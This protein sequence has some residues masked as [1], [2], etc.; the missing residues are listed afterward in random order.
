MYGMQ[1]EYHLPMWLSK[2]TTFCKTISKFSEYWGYL[3]L[4]SAESPFPLWFLMVQSSLDMVFISTGWEAALHLKEDFSF[5]TLHVI[6]P[7]LTICTQFAFCSKNRGICHFPPDLL[8]V[9]GHDCVGCMPFSHV[10]CW[11]VS[12]TALNGPWLRK[13]LLCSFST[14]NE[15]YDV[16][17]TKDLS[18]LFTSC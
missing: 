5:D 12:V 8:V 1:Y 9:I 16:V 15:S 3:Y 10:C 2:I 18:L 11:S 6:T 14:R 4:S 7:T 13:A 17:I